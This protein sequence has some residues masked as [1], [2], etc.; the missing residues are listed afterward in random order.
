MTDGET[1]V[2]LEALEDAPVEHHVDSDLA[3][4]TASNR[5]H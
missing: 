3:T 4:E 5:P 2:L 1:K